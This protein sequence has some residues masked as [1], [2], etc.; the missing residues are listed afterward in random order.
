MVKTYR[1]LIFKMFKSNIMRVLTISLIIAIGI[2]IVTSICGLPVKMRNAIENTSPSEQTAMASAIA[3]KVELLGLIFPI[4]FIAV[5]ALT[6]LATIT[7]LVEEERQ[8]LACLK[9]LG[10]S[11]TSIIIKYVFF[12]F[13]C[14]VFGCVLGLIIG[15]FAILPVLYEAVA[16][17]FGIGS[18]TR[19]IFITQGVMWSIIM[20]SAIILTALVISWRKCKEKPS[21]L[22]RAKAPKASKKI[23]LEYL[24]FVWKPLKF[25]Y[26]SSLRN[27]FR[28]KGRLFMTILSVIGSTIILF[29]GIGMLGSLNG[30]REQSIGNQNDFITSIIPISIVLITFGI[31]LAV[32][33]LFNL[34]NI[35]I[36]E[37]KREIATLRVLGYSQIEVAGFIFREILLL[38]TAG[39]IVGLP[40]GYWLLGFVFDYIDFGS[41]SFV[42]W[43]VWILTAIIGLLSVIITEILLYWKIKKVDMSSSLKTV[44]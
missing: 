23:I 40:L 7:R 29:C 13:V 11:N 43:Y 12:A 36:E 42:K 2:S 26:K 44:D 10:Y 37:R 35:N 3:D 1:K 18:S 24:P 20:S 19:D 22:L 39:I 41:L 15:N 17:R 32:L 25:K 21:N 30:M 9:T 28:Y 8:Q 31:A 27:I 34:T 5:A 16:F 4:F 14:A 38:S 33:V 6:A